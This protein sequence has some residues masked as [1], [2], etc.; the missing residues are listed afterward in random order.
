M[1]KIFLLAT[2]LVMILTTTAFA[3]ETEEKF[4]DQ[5]FEPQTEDA[6]DQ[7]DEVYIH[8][9]EEFQYTITCPIK[10][11]AV[12]QNPWQEPEKRGELLV[13]DNDGWTI[14]YAYYICVNAWNPDD[15]KIPD[16]N[17]GTTAAIGSYL[18][19]LKTNGGFGDARLV[20]VTKNNKGV[21]AI[22]AATIQVTN[23]ETGELEGEWVADRQD[24]YTFFRTPQGRCI[25]IQL[26][27]PELN[28]TF[29][30]TYQGSV[31]SFVDNSKDKKSKKDKKKDKKEKKDKQKD[32]KDKK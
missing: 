21:Y 26:V 32:K 19:D 8:T 24:L 5:A 18:T 4:G 17:K 14:R 31:M 1:R 7:P 25:S 6:V 22:T 11:L 3:E 30:K 29:V 16:F 20:N 28:K 15:A 23:K 13:F 9:S 12:V 2:L 27:T 10:P